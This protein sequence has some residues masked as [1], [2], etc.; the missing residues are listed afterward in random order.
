MAIHSSTTAW[1][2][3][4]TEEPG[5]LQ[6]VGHNWVTSLSSDLNSRL[7]FWNIYLFTCLAVL[8]LSCSTL[9][10]LR[11]LMPDPSLW[12]TDSLVTACSLNSRGAWDQLLRDMWDLKLP[13]QGWK[14]HPLH[15][16]ADSQSLDHQ[17][18][19]EQ[20]KFIILQSGSPKSKMG[21]TGPNSGHQQ[22]FLH[23]SWNF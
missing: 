5:R 15:S 4:W 19:P 20:Y 7:I 14:L 17:E 1:K 21:L 6:T 8:G 16:K 18:V 2:I 9:R 10:D 23:S 12:C 3:P 13:D 11:C 22:G